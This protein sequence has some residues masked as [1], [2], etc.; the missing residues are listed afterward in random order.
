MKKAKCED[1]PRIL[2]YVEKLVE[3]FGSDGYAVSNSVSFIYL[4]IY[5]SI[6][7]RV[8]LHAVYSFLISLI[9]KYFRQC[10]FSSCQ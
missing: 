9:N 1:A 7:R 8:D 2:G 4:S 3:K 5:L 10:G 6:K